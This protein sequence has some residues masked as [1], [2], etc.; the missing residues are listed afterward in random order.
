[1][2]HVT[3]ATT[4]GF[5]REVLFS[6]VPVVVDLYADG[7]G[8]CR[9]LAPLLERFARAYDGRLKFVKV[10]VDDESLVAEHYKASSVPTL[11][12]FDRGQLVYRTAGLPDP[13]AFVATLDRL[14]G[15][16]AVS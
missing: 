15:A 5:G 4:A 10:N 3:A 9:A 12:V 6:P 14:A 7:C 16:A 1:M 2:A 11:L 8:P 13:R